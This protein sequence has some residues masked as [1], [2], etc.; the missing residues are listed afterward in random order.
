MNRF[1]ILLVEDCDEDAY[2]FKQFLGKCANF[3]PVITRARSL[4]E[5]AD[6]IANADE[7]FD[8]VVLDFGL[9]DSVGINPVGRVKAMTRIPL[10][11]LSGN[12]DERAAKTLVGSG[13]LDYLV[14]GDVSGIEISQ[15]ISDAYSSTILRAISER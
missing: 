14:K 3:D 8:I 1:S 2:L 13:A 15:A 12:D 11:V 4:L 10:I 5:C 7:P 9:P 6:A